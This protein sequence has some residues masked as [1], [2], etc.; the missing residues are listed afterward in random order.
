MATSTP[1]IDLGYELRS[2]TQYTT[3]LLFSSFFGDEREETTLYTKEQ[4]DYLYTLQIMIGSL[5]RVLTSLLLAGPSWLI[6]T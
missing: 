4:L 6:G 3:R 1:G 2:L 5:V